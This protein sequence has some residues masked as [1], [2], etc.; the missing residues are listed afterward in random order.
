LVM[1]TRIR[2]NG[3]KHFLRNW[4]LGKWR[5]VMRVTRWKVYGLLVWSRLDHSSP[6]VG[7]HFGGSYG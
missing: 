6:I 5:L 3:V 7:I 4:R 1:G 2:G